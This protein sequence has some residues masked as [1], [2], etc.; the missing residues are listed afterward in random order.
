MFYRL[1]FIIDF[2]LLVLPVLGCFTFLPD[3]IVQV[4]LGMTLAW[5]TTMCALYIYNLYASSQH[6]HFRLKYVFDLAVVGKRPFVTDFRAYINIATAICILAVDFKIFP[7]R[8]A[9]AETYGSGLMD[10]GVGA[11][12]ISNAIVCPEARGKVQT[13]RYY[14]K[15]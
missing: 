13:E 12:A 3:S 10:V 14:T 6:R 7:R 9:K 4:L 15:F 8:F 5:M 11:F 2:I 1:K